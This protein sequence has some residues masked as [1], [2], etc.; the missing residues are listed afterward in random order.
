MQIVH[1]WINKLQYSNYYTR[2]HYVAMVN[3]LHHIM[4]LAK[5]TLSK[6]S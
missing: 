1:R 6:R 2:K 3:D 4:N 5:R